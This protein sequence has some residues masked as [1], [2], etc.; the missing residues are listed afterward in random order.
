MKHRREPVGEIIA[1][2]GS[3]AVRPILN[4]SSLTVST[5]TAV[6]ICLD[7]H[8]HRLDLALV[9]IQV[10]LGDDFLEPG[11]AQD[12]LPIDRSRSSMR[13]VTVDRT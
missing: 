11:A 10:E 5:T 6:R 12:L 4:A 2:R 8:L 13:I 3:R 9:R 7:D 1:V